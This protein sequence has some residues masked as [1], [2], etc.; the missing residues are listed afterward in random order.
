MCIY[1]K[2][3]H[4]SK[5]KDLTLTFTLENQNSLTPFS[6]S[7]KKGFKN[8]QLICNYGKNSYMEVLCNLS[9]VP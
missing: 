8:I 5:I 2:R 7:V 3:E 4:I 9:G 6:P 1:I